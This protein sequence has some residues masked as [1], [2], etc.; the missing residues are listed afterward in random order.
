MRVLIGVSVID[1]PISTEYN[2]IPFSLMGSTNVILE[3]IKRGEDDF[4]DR[5]FVERKGKTVVLRLYEHM[6]GHASVRLVL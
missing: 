3:T 6:G 5:S 4:D 1:H 2:N